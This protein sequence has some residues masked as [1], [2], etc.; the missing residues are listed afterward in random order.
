MQGTSSVDTMRTD[1]LLIIRFTL[2]AERL[3]R[4]APAMYLV[5]G[6]I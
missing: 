2:S 6:H 1:I 5:T 4:V 3:W